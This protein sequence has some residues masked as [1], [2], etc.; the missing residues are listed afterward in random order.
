MLFTHIQLDDFQRTL[1]RFGER[2][3]LKGAKVCAIIMTLVNIGAVYEDERPG[4][5]PP[6]L[7]YV[8]QLTF[9]M[10]EHVPRCPTSEESLCAW[11]I[12]NPYCAVVLMFL[13]TVLRHPQ[14][15][16]WSG[17]ARGDERAGTCGCGR[18]RRQRQMMLTSRCAPVLSEEWCLQG[19]EWVGR[20]VFE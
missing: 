14:T 4:E 19:M 17:A 18:R 11:S 3:E 7:E 8:L 15:L 12:L 20:K 16:L 1:A 13:A 6:V 2:L 5:H 10:L 9:P